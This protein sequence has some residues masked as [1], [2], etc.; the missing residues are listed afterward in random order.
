MCG[1]AAIVSPD[2]VQ[3]EGL[4]RMVELLGHRGPDA[5]GVRTIPGCALGHTRLSILD[6]S[7]G[8]QPMT[9]TAERYWIVFNGEV[10]N[11]QAL[12]DELGRRGH[13]FHTH[14]DTEVV[15]AAY[16]EWGRAC[17]DRFRGMFAFALWDTHEKTLFAARDLFGEKPLYYAVTPAGAL[18]VASELKAILA[19]G[20]IQPRLSLTSVDAFLTFGYVPPDRTIYENI[21][22]LPPAHCMEWRSGSVR[23]ERY[24]R[25]RF[26]TR[27]I[28]LPE[29]AKEVLRLMDQAVERQMVAD[30][31][32][33]AFLSGGLDSSTIV[34]LMQRHTR[35]PVKTFSVGFGED[36]NELP[37]ARA[38]ARRYATEH[39][40][41]DL[42]RPNVAELLLRMIDV[43]DEPFADTSHIPTFCLAGYARQFVKVVLSG[44]GGD[45]LFGGY[46]W[47]PDLAA[48]QSVR[49]A[50]A[51]WLLLRAL[52]RLQRNPSRALVRHGA[53]AGLAA[54]G[55]DLW[56]RDIV[57]VTV[58]RERRRR[59]LWAN[60]EVALYSPNGLFRPD[61]DVRGL[62]RAFHYDLTSF[63]PGDILVKVDRAA[64]AHGL[65]TRAP[66]L[67]R[68]LVEL[69]LSLPP[70]LKVN[71]DAMKVVMHEAFRHLWPEEL[72]GRRKQGFGSPIGS[73]MALPEVQ[74]MIH[75]VASRG[76]PLRELLPG[77]RE[78]DV[79]ERS[80]AG[81]ILLT[82]GL[83]LERGARG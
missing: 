54:S 15:I 34:A 38:V 78:S 42:G 56:K 82:L 61:D 47:Y 75:R 73:W 1:I 79:L 24:W 58:T 18:I 69:A 52:A 14:S 80:Y 63:L 36:I 59:R 49:F 12:R 26:E 37:Y 64:M 13:Q 28:A 44:D 32:V 23:V 51:Q 6:L 27:N 67:D 68:D 2:A 50:R 4:P 9:D 76:S 53:V 70:S 43:Y 46:S 19:S 66:F 29:A 35:E 11:F 3:Q 16:H 25:P 77:V 55:D 40:E 60:R 74:S 21:A 57:A 48:S 10:Y 20:A 41:I 62:D 45:E 83:W 30:V 8:A 71:G 39:H 81:W 17:L 72:H 33:G 31:P 5:Q 22:V 65:E 7:T